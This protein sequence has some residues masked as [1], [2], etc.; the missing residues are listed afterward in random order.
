MNIVRHVAETTVERGPSP[1]IFGDLSK[2]HSDMVRGKALLLFDDF[3]A[4]AFMTNA[5]A[6]GGYYTIQDS[7]VD[8]QGEDG[9]PDL[10]S[11]AAATA[12]G[13]LVVD[14]QASDNDE[15]YISFGYGGQ[16]VIDN[17]ASNTGKLMFEARIKKASVADNAVGVFIGLGTGPIAA[18][19]LVD[20]TATLITTKGFI[21]FH[22]LTDDGNTF[23]TVYQAA[24][25]SKQTVLANAATVTA[26]NYVKLGFLWDPKEIDAAKKIK[27]YVDGVLSNSFVST[28]NID[29]A[30]FPEGEAL[31]PMLLT[32]VGTAAESAVSIDWIACAQYQDSRN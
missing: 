13:V 5:G 10:G 9:P 1:V 14:S 29:A 21:G 11:T 23:D 31:V 15:G 17:A 2:I 19:Y 30:T 6:T 3:A 8:I 28:T 24:S 22:N 27:F 4:P 18:D 16:F 25:Q 32:K 26:A 7:G 20:D 12:Q